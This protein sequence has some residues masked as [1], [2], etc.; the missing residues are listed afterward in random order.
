MEQSRYLHFSSKSSRKLH[1][2]V[3]PTHFATFCQALLLACNG[4]GGNAAMVRELLPEM[5][6]H[7][8][9][10]GMERPFSR[11]SKAVKHGISPPSPAHVS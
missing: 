8:A 1:L 5:A 11:P 4:F 9:A 7:I 2:H 10:H 3:C 6:V